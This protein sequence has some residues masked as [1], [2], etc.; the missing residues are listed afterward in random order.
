MRATSPGPALRNRAAGRSR[1]PQRAEQLSGGK[2]PD[3]L[4]TLAAAYAAAG[5]FPEALATARKARELAVQQNNRTLSEHA[6][7]D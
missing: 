3:V 4:D 2:R 6:G 7:P 1:S 5:R